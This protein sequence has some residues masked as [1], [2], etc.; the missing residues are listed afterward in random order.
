MSHIVLL[1]GIV[2]LV[3]LAKARRAR[4]ITAQPPAIA[5]FE[6]VFESAPEPPDVP[7]MPWEPAP[8]IVIAEAP[9]PQVI[10][11]PSVPPTVARAHA[12]PRKYLLDGD[13]P[14][15]GR[16]DRVARIER[17]IRGRGL[18]SPRR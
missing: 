12:R 13:R 7:A 8:A 18:C 4:R 14:H 2:L 15:R 10:V 9:P 1:I 6:Q 16:I 11:Q 3:W 17:S 5:P